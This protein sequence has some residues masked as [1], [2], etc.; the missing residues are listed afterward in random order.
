LP[1][2][3]ADAAPAPLRLALPN[4]ASA[5]ETARQAVLAHLQGQA[6]SPRALYRLELVLEE[7][8]M[9]RFWHA[10]PQGGRHTVD[11]AVQLTA[12]T[13]EL[14][15]QDDGVA[16]DPTRAEPPPV[17]ASLQQA[18]PGGLGLML[19]RKAALACDYQRRDGHNRF[20]VTLART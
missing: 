6:L 11:L 12:E 13:L 3:A 18:R 16:F 1:N 4:D 2:S 5:V 15:F 7:T 8:L 10:F 19:T 14:C 17:A 20:T 9:N